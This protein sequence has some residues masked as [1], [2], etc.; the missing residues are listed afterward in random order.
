[1]PLEF[2]IRS[3]GRKPFASRQSAIADA[4]VDRPLPDE[5]PSGGRCGGRASGALGQ[6][7][8]LAAV[9]VEAD[10]KPVLELHAL[11][12]RS[13]QLQ[14]ALPLHFNPAAIRRA[15]ADLQSTCP[16]TY[17]APDDFASRLEAYEVELPA[18]LAALAAEDSARLRQAVEQAGEL[19]A[20]QREALL[21]NP[22]LGFSELLVLQRRVPP[23]RTGDVYW[24]WGQR[25]GMPVNWSCDFRPK[26]PPVAPWWADMIAAV[27][28]REGM[29]AA[30]SLSAPRVR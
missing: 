26:N 20:F 17:R 23:P 10:V 1:M 2:R 3:P 21:R 13:L 28:W 11:H 24:D 16:E 4:P 27:P 25:Y 29:A 30:R 22:L 18:V 7:T 5:T 12:Q 9:V 19:I 15:V 14:A 8:A 6:A